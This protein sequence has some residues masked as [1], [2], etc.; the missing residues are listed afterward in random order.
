MSPLHHREPGLVGAALDLP[1]VTVEVIADGIHLH[2]AVVRLLWRAVGALRLCL[3][4]DAVDVDLPG[5]PAARLDDGTLAGSRIGLDAAVRN[6]VAAQ[7]PLVD[8]LTMAS[9]TP[10]GALRL[11]HGLEVG[12]P[13]DLVLLSADLQVTTTVVGGRV[14]WQRG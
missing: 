9:L 10:A 5:G 1:D 11:R 13:A 14:V 4:S 6:L 8:A 12:A 2:P 3:V 7:V